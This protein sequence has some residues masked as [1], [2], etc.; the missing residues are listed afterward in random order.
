[1]A[2]YKDSLDNQRLE[3][4]PSDRKKML[5]L[6]FLM[7]KRVELP[8]PK[9]GQRQWSL[10]KELYGY[11]WDHFDKVIFDDEEKITEFT[12]ENFIS[13]HLIKGTDTH[14]ESF[15]DLVK[16]INLNTKTTYEQ[17]RHNQEH[18]KNLM[19][20]LSKLNDEETEIFVHLLHNKSRSQ[21]E[22]EQFSNDLTDM[23]CSDYTKR[24]LAKISEEANFAAK[25]RY[26][27]DHTLMKYAD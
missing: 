23:A 25:N 21:N 5:A 20:L 15:K 16:S 12:Y 13:P 1:M 10:F 7:S 8:E 26:H 4:Y 9:K 3:F 24:Q 19:P 18:F 27:L 17:H 6:P 11:D 22:K 14:S 2:E